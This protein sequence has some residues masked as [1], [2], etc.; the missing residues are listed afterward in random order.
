MG[1]K[2]IDRKKIKAIYLILILSNNLFTSSLSHEQN[3]TKKNKFNLKN[4]NMKS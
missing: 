3:Q 2:Q 1:Y 4:N